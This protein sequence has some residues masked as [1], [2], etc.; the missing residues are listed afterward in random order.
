[1]KGVGK[2]LRDMT[3]EQLEFETNVGVEL[4]TKLY[5]NHFR[6]E[7]GSIDKIRFHKKYVMEHSND[8]EV[9]RQLAEQA[10]MEYREVKQNI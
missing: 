1:M 10:V 5:R 9:L 8:P 3:L 4:S 6:I 2:V 7:C